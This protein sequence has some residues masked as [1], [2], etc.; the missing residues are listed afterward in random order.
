M[1]CTLR[2]GNYPVTTEMDKPCPIWKFTTDNQFKIDLPGI[3][4]QHAVSYHP[5]QLLDLVAKSFLLRIFIFF[6]FDKMME[7]WNG[8][9]AKWQNILKHGMSCCMKQKYYKNG[10]VIKS[11]NNS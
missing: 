7:R 6:L 5:V 9:T 2:K 4:F 11:E 3:G 8:E 1:A 10:I